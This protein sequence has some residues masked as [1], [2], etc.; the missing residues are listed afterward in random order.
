MNKFDRVFVV[1]AYVPNGGTFMAYHLGRLLQRDF[2]L[3]AIAVQTADETADNG[4]QDYDVRMPSVS[5]AEMERQITARDVLIANPSFSSHRF[6]ARLPG[7]KICYVQGFNTFTLLDLNFDCYVAVSD[8]VR[9]FLSTVYGLDVDVIPPFVDVD[10]VP[11]APAWNERP[12]ADVLCYG[13][14]DAEIW[15]WS[16][17]RLCDIARAHTPH[18][19]LSEPLAAR[20]RQHRD[21]LSVIGNYRYFLTLSPAEG[22]GLVPLEAMAMGTTVVGYDGFGG[23]HYLRDGENCAVAS[24]PHIDRVAEKLIDVTQRAD[25]ALQLAQAGR[26][27]AAAYSYDR[28]RADWIDRLSRALGIVAHLR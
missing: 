19:R 12:A 13:K 28:F 25:F 8:F 4:I 18:V 14:G 10:A 6:G 7:F 15:K 1:G 23:R 9:N 5:V 3:T 27:T 16:F 24:Y 2:G 20:G 21:L 22:F 26:E 11:P 17:E